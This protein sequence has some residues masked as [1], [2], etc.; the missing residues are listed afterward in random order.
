M[1][2]VTPGET[3]GT[4]YTSGVGTNKTKQHGAWNSSCVGLIARNTFNTF[5]P[6]LQPESTCLRAVS[7]TVLGWG[8]RPLVFF[9]RYLA[10]A[11]W[12]GRQCSFASRRQIW[13]LLSAANRLFDI[14]RWASVRVRGQSSPHRAMQRLSPG[15]ARDH[16]VMEKFLIKL[17][18]SLSLSGPDRQPL[19]T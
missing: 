5:Q 13:C 11:A 14:T 7:D 19:R 15:R 3:L 4:L 17:S 12:R 9:A 16:P 6:S 2:A 18:L 1:G 10:G 8:S